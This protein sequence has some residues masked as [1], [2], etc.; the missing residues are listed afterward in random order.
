[1]NTLG[2][3]SSTAN[4]RWTA[5]TET[6]SGSVTASSRLATAEHSLPVRVGRILIV[7]DNPRARQSM[8][9]ALT[10]AGH[11][12]VAL[13]SAVEALQQISRLPSL[14]VILTDLQMPGMDGLAFIRALA[15]RRCEAQVVMVTAFASVGSAVEAMRYGAF[16]YIE[17]PFDVEQIEE[18][19]L[20][21]MRHGEKVGRRSTMGETAA[22][23]GSL[24]VG[25]SPAMHRLRLAIAQAAPT[26]ETVLIS[27]ESGTGKELVAKCLH[28]ASRRSPRALVGLNCPALSPQL[29][30]S[31]LFG[32]ERGAFT[33]ADAPRVGRFELAEGGTL[34]LDEITEIDFGLQAKLL[35]VLQERTYE[36]VGS[37]QSRQADV[38]IVATTNRDLR[39]EVQAGRFRQDLFYRLNVLP[40]EVPPLRQRLEDVP[41][42]VE[43][44][45]RQ[46]PS[47]WGDRATR[48]PPPRS[49]CSRT[50]IGPAMSGN[51]KTSPPGSA[52]WDRGASWPS[53]NSGCGCSSRRR[54]G[55]R[56][57][58][59]RDRSARECGWRTWNAG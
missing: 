25:Q 18:I 46:P 43:H 4:P 57:P 29:M 16:D 10:A 21:A 44:F 1:M 8:A 50:T 38:R 51:S 24:M 53:T 31:E 32:H 12:V 23:W 48:C 35:R 20:R 33:S 39:A 41:L 28:S 7:D 15:E 14:D 55:A 13:A 5:R 9:E 17:K 11:E 30:E 42:L 36:R 37:S 54:S 3:Q 26:D 27:G 52:C 58:R 2:T 49:I 22:D 6:R 45:C 56:R 40:I 34:L 19:V 47:G 59:L